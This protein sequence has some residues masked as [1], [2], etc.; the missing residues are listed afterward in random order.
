MR[1]QNANKS[2][3]VF[4]QFLLLMDMV[5]LVLHSFLC[6]QSRMVYF[7]ISI[8][9]ML[10]CSQDE[11][12]PVFIMNNDIPID[13]RKKMILNTFKVSVPKILKKSCAVPFNPLVHLLI[14]ISELFS[15]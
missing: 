14:N 5:I 13:E 6:C 9:S 15:N 10:L 2:E 11:F 12:L 3:I 7:L 4:S 8:N 1:W